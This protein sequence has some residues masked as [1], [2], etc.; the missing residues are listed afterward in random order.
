MYVGP[1]LHNVDLGAGNSSRIGS[2][3]FAVMQAKILYSV[4]SNLMG[5]NSCARH[6]TN[7]CFCLSHLVPLIY[8]WFNRAS[9]SSLIVS[10]FDL[11][12]AR[13]MPSHTYFAWS[14]VLLEKLTSK[15]CS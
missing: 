14:R 10:Q 4:F 11:K 12:K 6:T 9:M 8:I 15:L 1:T 13:P 5:A 2:S 3:L 7:P